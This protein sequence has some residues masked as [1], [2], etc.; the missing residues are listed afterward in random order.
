MFLR[1]LDLPLESEI[2]LGWCTTRIEKCKHLFHAYGRSVD[3]FIS[4]LETLVSTRCMLSGIT[5]DKA[6]VTCRDFTLAL[7]RMSEMEGVVLED[8]SYSSLY[9]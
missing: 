8:S 1:K 9:S 5:R 7:A 3:D 4:I 6:V 2:T